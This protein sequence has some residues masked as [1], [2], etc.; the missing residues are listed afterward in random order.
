MVSVNVSHVKFLVR[1]LNAHLMGQSHDCPYCR[2]KVSFPI[3]RRWLVLE[4]RRCGDCGLMYRYP[5]DDE[6]S[7]TRYY[8]SEYRSPFTTE[9]PS[10]QELSKLLE[11][12]FSGTS[13]DF[14]IE[15]ETLKRQVPTGTV[16]DYGCSW[17]YGAWQLAQAGYR[18]VGYEISQPRASYAARNLGCNV[19]TS[20]QELVRNHSGAFNAIFCHHVLE[21]LP[22]LCGVLDDFHAMLARGGVLM[23]F[24]PDCTGLNGKQ[25][26]RS[27]GMKHTMAFD[28]AFFRRN[29]PKHG[30]QVRVASGPS[31]PPLDYFA[32]ED[33]PYHEG[34]Y[35]FMVL[36]K[37]V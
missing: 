14:R 27:V 22:S 31:T 25:L 16:L 19:T 15:I 34:G 3:L 11:R 5:K 33:V 13:K 18:V 10:E 1:M 21:H 4:L 9:L 32:T 8:Q 35:E 12:G 26:R 23:A 30:L 36:G 6:E 20:R 37:K 7:S 2:S 29:L 24:V 17:G 28:A